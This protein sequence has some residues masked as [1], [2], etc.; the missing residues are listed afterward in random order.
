MIDDFPCH[1]QQTIGSCLP[2]AVYSLLQYLGRADIS[3]DEIA[4]LCQVGQG[5]YCSWNVAVDGLAAAFEVESFEDDWDRVHTEV[6]EN[7]NPVIV[8]ISPDRRMDFIE[9]HAVVVIGAP[10][11]TEIA[12]G[13]VAYMDPSDGAIQRQPLLTFLRM[14]DIPGAR[15]LLLA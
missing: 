15:C 6:V 1:R 13:V 8:T 10:A 11:I 7:S 5:G 9:D 12:H 3:M 2:T 4:T 14:W